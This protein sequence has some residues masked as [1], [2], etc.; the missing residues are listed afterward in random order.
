MDF[1][2]NLKEDEAVCEGCKLRAIEAFKHKRRTKR[3]VKV[4]LEAV[5][6]Q[7]ALNT[8]GPSG[9]ESQRKRPRSAEE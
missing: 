9:S 4:N 1:V 8:L 7:H 3:T 2:E 6:T 5:G